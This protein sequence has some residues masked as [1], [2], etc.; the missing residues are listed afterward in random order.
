MAAPALLD[1]FFD[2]SLQN[3]FFKKRYGYW[4]LN[5]EDEAAKRNIPP[6]RLVKA[7]INGKV[8]WLTDQEAQGLLARLEDPSGS[9]RAFKASLERALHG[10]SQALADEVRVVISLTI[11]SLHESADEE[12]L[13]PEDLKR[14]TTA[15]RRHF[16][17]A[18]AVIEELFS[19][20]KELQQRMGEDPIIVNYERGM[21]AL[22]ELQKQGREEEAAK[23][24]QELQ[25]VKQKYLL[26]TRPLEPLK[27]TI[28]FYRMDLQK[29]KS[30]VMVIHLE[31]NTARDAGLHSQ[32]TNLQERLGKAKD[33]PWDDLDLE[34]LD[35]QID[36]R[37]RDMRQ[38]LRNLKTESE[39][40]SCNVKQLD[41]VCR[42]IED[43]VFGDEQIRNATFQRVQKLRS[44]GTQQENKKTSSNGMVF[45]K[46][47][48]H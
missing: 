8:H 23:L 17:D 38:E 5:Q 40:T 20:E 1:A 6:K 28:S 15:L 42:W 35:D 22:L 14:F 18:E 9:D 10:E 41:K 31:I 13:S 33:H 4:Q 34:D 12:S 16:N 19:A 3:Y 47:R 2:R 7:F 25:K 26:R 21:A 46:H 32:L 29:T 44:S 27:Y 36:P 48:L 24:A 30:K 45:T 43:K 39:F 37:A 11:Q